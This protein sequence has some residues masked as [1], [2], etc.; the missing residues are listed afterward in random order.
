[1]NIRR[2][3]YTTKGADPTVV[4]EWVF[5]SDTR[6]SCRDC[7]GRGFF[8]N[9]N[10]DSDA[11]ECDACDGRGWIRNWPIRHYGT[12]QEFQG[13]YRGEGCFEGLSEEE[14]KKLHDAHE[15]AMNECVDLMREMAQE[16]PRG[17]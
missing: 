9:R 10:D 11:V 2:K 7:G 5:T 4:V 16:G 8:A 14:A 12:V 15:R 17:Y 3:E 13:I 6:R 1:M